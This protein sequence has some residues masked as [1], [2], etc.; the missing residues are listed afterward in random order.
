M[1]NQA[2]V[3]LLNKTVF[4]AVLPIPGAFPRDIHFLVAGL[5]SYPSLEMTLHHSFI[6]IKLGYS[7]HFLVHMGRFDSSYFFHQIPAT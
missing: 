4:I 5:S 3:T 1:V 6:S 2:K 7:N